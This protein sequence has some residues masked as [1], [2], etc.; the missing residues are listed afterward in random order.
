MEAEEKKLQLQAEAED[1]KLQA[2]EKKLQLQAEEKRLELEAEREKEKHKLESDMKKEEMRLNHEL[3]M[4]KIKATKSSSS[5]NDPK[6]R[7]IPNFQEN[8]D[9]IDGYLHRFELCAEAAGWPKEKWASQLIGVLTGR[10]LQVLLSFNP[11]EIKDY[12][13]LKH[14]LLNAFQ[15]NAEGFRAKFRTCKPEKDENFVT[16]MSR[17]KLGFNRWL[18]LSNIDNQNAAEIIDFIIKDQV[19]QIC[20]PDLVSHIKEQQPKDCA[21]LTAIAQRYADAHPAKSLAK[22]RQDPFVSGGVGNVDR[23]R[24]FDKRMQGRRGYSENRSYDNRNTGQNT[25]GSQNRSSMTCHRCGMTGHFSAKCRQ[26]YC[27]KCDQFGHPP[28]DSK[29][30]ST[31]KD[32]KMCNNCGVKGHMYYQCSACFRCGRQGHRASDCHSKSHVFKPALQER[33]QPK[34]NVASVQEDMS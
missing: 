2:E 29:N 8:K 15:C 25:H 9:Q 20:H 3:E 5:D 18:E 12:E 26:P 4:A 33:R 31:T 6:P 13:K 10:A 30:T 32:S 34:G 1:K 11:E 24:T 23:G 14:A 21:E 16:F 7:N 17:L 27:D 28:C 22:S 19:Y